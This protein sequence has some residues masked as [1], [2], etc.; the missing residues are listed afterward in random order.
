MHL[1]LID[2]RQKK[3]DG[4]SACSGSGDLRRVRRLFLHLETSGLAASRH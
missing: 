3:G 1:T 4:C 2:L